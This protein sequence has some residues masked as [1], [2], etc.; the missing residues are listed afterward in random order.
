MIAIIVADFKHWS[1]RYCRRSLGTVILCVTLFGCFTGLR[2]EFCLIGFMAGFI[3]LGILAGDQTWSETKIE[4]WVINTRLT[5]VQI[6]SG[7]ILGTSFILFLHYLMMLPIIFLMTVL[8]GIGWLEI[9]EITLL[10]FIA[11][12]IV[13]GFGLI[14]WLLH[15]IDNF[16]ISRILV[17]S[18]FLIAIAVPQIRFVNPFYQI[19][20]ITAP[21]INQ[22]IW[23]GIFVNLGWLL[24]IIWITVLFLKME[25]RKD[26]ECRARL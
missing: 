9:V 21:A 1:A 10:M 8:W 14:A 22:Q 24:L 16:L 25:V 11:A 2:P 6:V 18:W 12:L 17:I 19:W 3:W 23:A 13:T 15:V 26:Y 5:P 4:S 7:K 20:M